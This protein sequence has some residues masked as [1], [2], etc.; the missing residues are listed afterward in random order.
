MEGI[1]LEKE[2][3]VNARLKLKEKLAI[4]KLAKNKG[5]EGLTGLLK[6][7]AVAKDV[8]IKL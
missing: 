3:Q 8:Q 1:D 6:M 5:A 4:I 7:L 2:V